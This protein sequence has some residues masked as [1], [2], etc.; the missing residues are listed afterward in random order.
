MISFF[1]CL[2][3]LKYH[4][5][6]NAQKQMNNY[7]FDGELS[8]NVINALSV[9]ITLNLYTGKAT[10]AKLT[11]DQLDAGTKVQNYLLSSTAYIE[12]HKQIKALGNP[13]FSF[14]L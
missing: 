1:P 13:R 12:F 10:I 14:C 6:Q 3:V 2:E 11:V 7:I 5:K 9:V 8:V 4:R